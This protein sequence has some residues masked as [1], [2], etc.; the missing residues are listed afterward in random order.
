MVQSPG[1]GIVRITYNEQDLPVSV[2]QPNGGT[3]IY[4]YDESGNLIK[5]I[6]P[7]NR[8]SEYNWENGILKE[9]IDPVAGRTRLYYDEQLNLRRVD[10]P[11]H[12]REQWERD[13]HGN[14]LVYTNAK[15][16]ETR[17]KYDAADRITQLYLPDGNLVDY[18]YDKDGRQASGTTTPA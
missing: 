9:L 11:D 1:R 14:T 18:T 8:L 17:Y 5:R 13:N 4:Q 16:A 3:W 2:I 10:Y 7:E 15:G 12:T 6:N